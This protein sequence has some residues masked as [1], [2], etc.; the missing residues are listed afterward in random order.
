MTLQSKKAV[1]VTGGAPSAQN[2][3]N[4][5][6]RGSEDA[7]FGLQMPRGNRRPVMAGFRFEGGSVG[8]PTLP[9]SSVAGLKG[10]EAQQ[11]QPMRMALAGHQ[12]P[13]ALAVAFGTSAAHEAPMVQEE[14]Q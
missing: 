7:V 5:L 12:F 1:P 13:R 6:G 10:P 4:T 9:G 11:R 3:K 8:R 2:S 14:L